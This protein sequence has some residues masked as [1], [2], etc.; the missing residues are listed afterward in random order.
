MQHHLN[1]VYQILL[2]QFITQ[3]KNPINKLWPYESGYIV[4]RGYSSDN[5]LLISLIH[6]LRLNTNVLN[7]TITTHPNN[8]HIP[9]IVYGNYLTV[10]GGWGVRLSVIITPLNDN[11]SLVPTL[12][13]LFSPTQTYSSPLIFIVPLLWRRPHRCAH[14]QLCIR[15][16]HLINEKTITQFVILIIIP[17]ECVSLSCQRKPDAVVSRE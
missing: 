16:C 15:I 5:S 7:S 4:S 9:I 11:F 13:C 2:Q 17:Y 1:S 12:I 14:V 3:F 6:T 10:Y 8:I